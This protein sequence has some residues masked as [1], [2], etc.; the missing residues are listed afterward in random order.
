VPD[1]P[2]ARS[3]QLSWRSVTVL[4]D[5]KDCCLRKLIWGPVSGALSRAVGRTKKT[6]RSMGDGRRPLLGGAPNPDRRC[7]GRGWYDSLHSP[8]RVTQSA[9]LLSRLGDLTHRYMTQRKIV[10]SGRHSQSAEIFHDLCNCPKSPSTT[11]KPEL[12]ECDAVLCNRSFRIRRI[13]PNLGKVQSHLFNR[14]RHVR[15]PLDYISA[16][17]EGPCVNRNGLV[18]RL[19]KFLPSCLRA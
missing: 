13:C 9:N 11:A 18:C 6:Q 2:D 17:S 8:D 16:A 5:A 10:P 4:F 3:R 12:I 1:C 19:L 15:K 7:W 14:F